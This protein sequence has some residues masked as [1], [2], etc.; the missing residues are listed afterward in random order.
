MTVDDDAAGRVNGMVQAHEIPWQC[1]ALP[2]VLEGID[3]LTLDVDQLLHYTVELQHETAVLRDLSHEAIA[4]VA[5]L[6]TQLQ[7]AMRV[8]A[9]Q[10]QQLRDDRERAA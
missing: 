8:I 2:P 10:R 7:R 3:V 5:R 6:T 9:W 4:H 1:D